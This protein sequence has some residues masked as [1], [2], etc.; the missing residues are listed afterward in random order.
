MAG[1]VA[2]IHSH[3]GA[4]LQAPNLA[5]VQILFTNKTSLSC[6]FLL[7]FLYHA[8]A[9]VKFYIAISFSPKFPRVFCYITDFLV[10]RDHLLRA[11][12]T[13]L[14]AHRTFDYENIQTKFEAGDTG[15]DRQSNIQGSLDRNLSFFRS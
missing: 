9:G 6:C 13:K 11:T 7:P 10:T 8:D 1:L 14:Q 3:A 15:E 2:L 12:Y 5:S 4:I